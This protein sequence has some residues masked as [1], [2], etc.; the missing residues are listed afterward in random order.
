MAGKR[1]AA[2]ASVLQEAPPPIGWVHAPQQDRSRRT[3]SRLL[4]ATEQ[5]IRRDGVEAV[6]VP[7]VAREAG[8]SVG[9]FYAR[10]PDKAAL[11]RTLHQR[12][13]EETQSTA[14]AALDPARWADVGTEELVRL[15]IGFAVRLFHQR[16]PMMLAFA[17]TL[18]GD[19]GFAER[20]ARS[21][22]VVAERLRA[23]LLARRA[24]LAHPRPAEAIDMSLR[25]VTATLEQRNALEAGGPEATVSD[26]HLAGELSRMVIGYLGIRR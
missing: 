4:D 19:P 25:V 1:A 24:D 11:L 21:A 9:S 16:K 7:A 18:G 23:L 8:S 22:A 2:A 5:I 3:L 12:A 10:F 14:A 20:R 6:T 17:S 26:E 13:C 15:F